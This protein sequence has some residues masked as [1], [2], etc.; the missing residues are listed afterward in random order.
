MRTYLVS[1]LLLAGS[2]EA[3][4]FTTELVSKTYDS[5]APAGG[6]T[7]DIS[8][9][10]RFVLFASRLARI[11]PNDTINQGF[12]YFVFDRTTG[13]TE[14]VNVSS[15]EEPANDNR[16]YTPSASLSADGR[17]VAFESLATNLARDDTDEEI[18][19]FLRDRV[20]GTTEL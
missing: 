18:D 20:A 6:V 10:G 17:Y 12:D 4:A 15:N 14:Q 7:M 1:L 2:F 9:D 11:V 16:S 19:V 3:Q 8:A 5:A 13:R